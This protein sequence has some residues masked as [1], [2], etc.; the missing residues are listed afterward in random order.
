MLHYAFE[1]LEFEKVEFRIDER[2]IRSLKAVEKL[3]ATLE[4]T[5]RSDTLM[6]NGFRRNTRCYGLLKEEWAKVKKTNFL[7]FN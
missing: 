4:G 7:N 1:V 6:L 2:N 5:L 3:G